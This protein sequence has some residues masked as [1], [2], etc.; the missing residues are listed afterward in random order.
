MTN[1]ADS[2][3]MSVFESFS[4]KAKATDKPV[5]GSPRQA[6]ARIQV[7]ARIESPQPATPVKVEA[8]TQVPVK[9]MPAKEVPVE[10]QATQPLPEKVPAKTGTTS[11]GG[12]G[13]N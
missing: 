6:P 9:A 4:G 10:K 5:V 8:P 12:D 11:S 1:T 7:P 13:G 3:L 2:P